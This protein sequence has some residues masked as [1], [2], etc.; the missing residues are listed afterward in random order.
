METKQVYGSTTDGFLDGRLMM[1]T[2]IKCPFCNWTNVGFHIESHNSPM[3]F[4][5]ICSH[6][7]AME[8]DENDIPIFI[9]E[10]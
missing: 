9:F 5:L 7:K 4:E 10:K 6:L 2:E 8:P 1:T 3:K